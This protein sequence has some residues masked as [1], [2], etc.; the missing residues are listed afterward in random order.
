LT[1]NNNNIKKLY[2]IPSSHKYGHLREDKFQIVVGYDFINNCYIV[3]P[4]NDNSGLYNKVKSSEVI[5][6]TLQEALDEM[7]TLI[8]KENDK[9]ET[10]KSLVNAVTMKEKI[11][12][13]PNEWSHLFNIFREV[14]AQLKFL[15]I[16]L[17]NAEKIHNKK[18]IKMYTHEI[19][20]TN[21]AIRRLHKRYFYY[22]GNRFQEIEKLVLENDFI[23][24]IDNVTYYIKCNIKKLEI[25]KELLVAQ[26]SR[27]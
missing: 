14:N 11:E 18:Y 8:K 1:F 4:L 7:D 9:I 6:Y 13:Q 25:Q 26:Y 17:K 22:F 20:K 10:L 24:N 27:I 12:K 16:H 2:K 15:N 5:F 3:S 23:N 19:A 21:K